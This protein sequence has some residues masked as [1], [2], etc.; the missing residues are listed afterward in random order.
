MQPDF[1]ILRAKSDAAAAIVVQSCKRISLILRGFNPNQPRDEIGRWTGGGG[2]GFADRQPLGGVQLAQGRGGVPPRIPMQ[3]MRRIAGRD[4][5]RP[6]L[7]LTFSF[8]Y[9]NYIVQQ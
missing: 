6:L 8:G 3:P 1:D 4:F 5:N 2:F 7:K 9:A